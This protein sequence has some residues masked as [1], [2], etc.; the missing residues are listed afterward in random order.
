MCADDFVIVVAAVVPTTKDC[1]GP[2]NETAGLTRMD[3]WFHTEIPFVSGHCRTT[4]H[5]SPIPTGHPTC[6]VG[7]AAIVTVISRLRFFQIAK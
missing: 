2:P 5:Y 3:Q 1:K 6:A 4:F 7:A